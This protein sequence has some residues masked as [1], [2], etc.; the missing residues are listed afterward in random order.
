LITNALG[1]LEWVYYHSRP[2]ANPYN[3]RVVSNSWGA[4]GGRYDPE[5]AV[6]QLIEKIT[7]EN[8]VVLVFAAGNSGGNGTGYEDDEGNIQP[9][10]SNYANTPVAIGVAASTRDGDG[11]AEFSSR[12]LADENATYPDLA[13]PGVNIWST[14]ARRTIISVLNRD[15]KNPYYFPI[16]GTSMATPH[17]AGAVALLWQACPSLKVSDK[18]EDYNGADADQWRKNPRTR[19]HEAEWILEATADYIP[20]Q[21]DNGVPENATIC[22]TTGAKYDFAQGYGL[23]NIERA[24]AVA[25]TLHELR[26]RDFDRDGVLD[27]P[28]ATVEDALAQYKNIM[29]RY[30]VEGDTNKLVNNWHG[31]WTRFTNQ[32]TKLNIVETDM[33]HYIYI[34][35]E[36]EGLIID[37]DFKSI[38]TE[39]AAVGT[40]SVVIDCDGDGEPD[41]YQERVSREGHKHSELDLSQEPFA[42]ARGRLWNF[43]IEGHGF[44]IPFINLYQH[45]S[46]GEARIEFDVCIQVIVGQPTH[47]KFEDYRAVVGQ[48]RLAEEAPTEKYAG[49]QITLMTLCYDLSKVQPLILP[50]VV[51][52]PAVP[53]FP[54]ELV[55]TILAILLILA[56]VVTYYYKKLRSSRSKKNG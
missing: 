11:I 37:L 46:Y 45:T 13:A 6:S 10:T 55:I 4:G 3:I 31:E 8:N 1:G 52:K 36:A 17:I 33:S 51:R 32:S 41:W 20:Y 56:T 48:L 38:R 22:A 34:P 7:Y 54:W 47:I 21:E 39:N 24:V 29:E 50:P 25:L 44:D 53:R 12:G 35:L 2:G 26:T 9:H 49:G 40:L 5:D 14:A 15:S 43:N 30:I 19:I 18:H 28:Q 23:V 27:Y 16:S 42:G